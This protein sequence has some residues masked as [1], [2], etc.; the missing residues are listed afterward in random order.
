MIRAPTT[1]CPSVGF[2]PMMI[3][4]PAASMSSNEP[5]APDRPSEAR[6]ANDVGEWQNSLYLLPVFDLNASI[7]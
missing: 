7:G 6:S 2:A 3:A 1:G 4:A 5:V